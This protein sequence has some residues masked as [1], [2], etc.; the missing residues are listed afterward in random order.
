[1]GMSEAEMSKTPALSRAVVAH[2][3]NDQLYYA[4]IP[5]LEGLHAVGRTEADALADLRE[6]LVSWAQA[7]RSRGILLPEPE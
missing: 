7:H 2:L 4:C 3:D 6:G 1:M 5:G